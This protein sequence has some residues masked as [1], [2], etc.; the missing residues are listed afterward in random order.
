MESDELTRYAEI[1]KSVVRRRSMQTFV[2]HLGMYLVGNAF[3]GGWNALTYYVTETGFIWFPLPLL[4][5]GIGVLI[6][7]WNSIILF[8]RW[9]ERDEENIKIML[10]EPE[11]IEEAAN[12]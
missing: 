7:Y 6:H 3:F 12:V 2:A 10:G 5:W 4:F 9:W 1:R 11:R 8:D